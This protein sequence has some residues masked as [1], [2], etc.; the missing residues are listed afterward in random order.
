MKTE[1]IVCRCIGSGRVAHH[2]CISAF[3]NLIQMYV[4]GK[5]GSM[6]IVNGPDD[7]K[8]RGDACFTVVFRL[9][10]GV[11]WLTC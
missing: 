10:E 1:V 5:T 7:R 8:E 6:T 4:P 9:P 3:F 11:T 2:L